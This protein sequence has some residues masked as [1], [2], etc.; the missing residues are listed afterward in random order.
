VPDV[1]LGTHFLSELVEMDVLYFA[2][3]PRREGNRLDEAWLTSAPNRLAEFDRDASPWSGVI[4]VAHGGDLAGAGQA[5]RILAH[6]QD[7]RVCLYSLPA[8]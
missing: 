1:S 6:A 8:R 4:H 7:Q 5:L 2:L 3:F